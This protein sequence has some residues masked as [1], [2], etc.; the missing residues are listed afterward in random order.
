MSLNLYLYLLYYIILLIVF[1]LQS[2]IGFLIILEISTITFIILNIINNNNNSSSKFYKSQKYIYMI[3]FSLINIMD[4]Y[5]LA[6]FNFQVKYVNLLHNF[7]K[8]LFNDFK[9]TYITYYNQNSFFVSLIV[10][11]F[12]IVTIGILWV[13]FEKFANKIKKIGLINWFFTKFFKKPEPVKYDYS[14]KVN[15][16]CSNT[17]KLF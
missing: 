16:F 7:F 17:K 1:N 15:K 4:T 8:P 6:L 14:S 5:Y 13:S 11:F 9:G 3:Y 10:I 12:L 2:F